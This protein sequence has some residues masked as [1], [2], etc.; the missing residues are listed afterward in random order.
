[1]MGAT[2]VRSDPEALSRVYQG[3][4]A[5]I[6]DINLIR[7]MYSQ[8]CQNLHMAK[9]VFINNGLGF[10]LPQNAKYKGAINNM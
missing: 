1:M 7:Y 2:M 4:A 8:D 9:N 3:S 6:I 10:A 5:Y